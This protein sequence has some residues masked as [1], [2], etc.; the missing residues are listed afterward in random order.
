MCGFI[1]LI[2]SRHAAGEL[3]DSL[4]VL[5]HR[6]QDAAGISSFDGDRFHHRRGTGMVRDVFAES[7]M[8]R[9]PGSMALGHTR[10]PT[11]GGGT[12]M[13]AQ[14][15][16]TNTPYGI[17]MAH[18]GNVTNFPK[19]KKSLLEDDG[20]RL[21]TTCDVE[22][23]LN[24]FAAALS[25]HPANGACSWD[26][27]VME[28][29]Q[30]VFSRVRGSYSGVAM[31]GGRGLVAFRDPYGI[32]PAI[33]GKREIDGRESFAVASESVALT[34]IGFDPVR[35]LKPGEVVLIDALGMR[36]KLL[37]RNGATEHRP[38]VFEFIYFARPDSV[39]DDISVYKARLRLGACL[40]E[41]IKARGIT[42][43][44][45]VPVPDSARPAALE[46][47]WKLRVH[48]REGL[49]K[50]RY[51]GRTFIMPGQANRK[52]NVRA[53]LTVLPMELDGKGVLLVDDSVVRGTT[54][55]SVV[56]MVRKAGATAVYIGVA[57][58]RIK[59]PCVYGVDM[60]TRDEFLAKDERSDEDIAKILGADAIVYLPLDDMVDAVRGPTSKVDRFCRACMDGDY[61][62]GDIDEGVLSSI[63]SERSRASRNVTK[64]ECVEG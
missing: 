35:D 55:K 31:V 58:P 39:I 38:C 48:Y 13:D 46:C 21:S 10:Y 43:D 25:R 57:S 61:P 29:M 8:V 4:L 60:Q 64:R 26:D 45:V 40:A 17:A 7:D 56:D 14:P 28:S 19:L 41:H 63:E 54:T 44:V 49:L 32:K 33:L 1:G 27:T 24:V 59:H 36:S 12:A 2:G 23:I 30:E 42:P 47:A 53:K 22:A 62:T 3:A 15:L 18:N 50:N 37:Q 11:V 34:V 5:Q 6:G 9:L 51:V 20:R 16:Y 52:K